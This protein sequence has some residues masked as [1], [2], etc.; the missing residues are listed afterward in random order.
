MPCHNLS[1]PDYNLPE[2]RGPPTDY[3]SIYKIMPH[4]DDTNGGCLPAGVRDPAIV[5]KPPAYA[6]LV[7]SYVYSLPILR[8]G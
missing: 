5:E 7:V 2:H 3:D 6:F 1:F 8:P 4:V